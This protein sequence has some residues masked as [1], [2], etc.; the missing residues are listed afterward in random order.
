[1]NEQK[2]FNLSELRR[3]DAVVPQRDPLSLVAGAKEL[4]PIFNNTFVED[5]VSKTDGALLD[6]TIA[7]RM[8]RLNDKKNN[9]TRLNTQY[10]KT[11][12]DLVRQLQGTGI[13]KVGSRNLL[14]NEQRVRDAARKRELA[15]IEE[16]RGN[17][18]TSESLRSEASS[19]DGKTSSEILQGV[20]TKI[21][22]QFGVD[23]TTIKQLEGLTPKQAAQVIYNAVQNPDESNTWLQQAWNQLSD[24]QKKQMVSVT[25]LTTSEDET[26]LSGLEDIINSTTTISNQTPVVDTVTTNTTEDFDAEALFQNLN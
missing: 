22:T 20:A 26:S 9:Y 6:G 15:D 10:E 19:I 16:L 8:Q 25:G 3:K 5:T 2:Q 1:M 13:T 23:E 14:I 17:I 18:E 21:G 7:Q 11:E 12:D 24:I 4:D